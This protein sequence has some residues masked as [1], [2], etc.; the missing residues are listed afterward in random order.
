MEVALDN[1]EAIWTRMDTLLHSLA[2]RQ[3]AWPFREPVNPVKANI[4][5]YFDVIKCAPTRLGGQI[6]LGYRIYTL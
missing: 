1:V 3:T 5:D 6:E 4:P 2:R